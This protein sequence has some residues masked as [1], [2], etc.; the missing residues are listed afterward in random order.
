MRR[1]D[2]FGDRWRNCMEHQGMIHQKGNIEVLAGKPIAVPLCLPQISHGQPPTEPGLC[3]EGPLTSRRSHDTTPETTLVC[4]VINTMTQTN[5]S[6]C[7]NMGIRIF[8]AILPIRGLQPFHRT[9]LPSSWHGRWWRRQQVLPNRWS[10]WLQRV[11]TQK[12]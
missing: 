8:G 7:T 5:L 6:K 4:L 12:T 2:S 10:T 3:G 11:L 1:L 9:L